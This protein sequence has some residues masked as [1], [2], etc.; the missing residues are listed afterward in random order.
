MPEGEHRPAGDRRLPLLLRAKID[1]WQATYA[2]L[3]KLA[4]AGQ[5]DIARNEQLKR[6]YVRL[7]EELVPELLAIID[8]GHLREY[9]AEDWQTIE[10]TYGDAKDVLEGNWGLS[11]FTEY[12]SDNPELGDRTWN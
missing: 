6:D 7:C 10:R 2:E 4:R 12:R 9:A 5:P 11:S 3:R 1:Q 8:S